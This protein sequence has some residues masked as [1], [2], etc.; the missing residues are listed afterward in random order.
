MS[1]RSLPC[2]GR[3]RVKGEEMWVTFSWTWSLKETLPFSGDLQDAV[4]ELTEENGRLVDEKTVL[5]ESLCAQTEKLET[6]RTQVGG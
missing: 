3:A 6:T 4:N 2:L 1:T 5:L